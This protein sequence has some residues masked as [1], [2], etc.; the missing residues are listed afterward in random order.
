MV[1]QEGG[2]AKRKKRKSKWEAN[3]RVKPSRLFNT[4]PHLHS[5]ISNRE[6]TQPIFSTHTN[7][8]THQYE[9]EIIWQNLSGDAALFRL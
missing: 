6:R 1:K 5:K 9:V 3:H 2:K 4:K 7:L 8:E